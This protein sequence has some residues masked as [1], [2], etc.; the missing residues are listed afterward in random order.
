MK[1]N[2]VIAFR[3]PADF[4]GR[5]IDGSAASWNAQAFDPGD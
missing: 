4:L 3:N 2:I 5:P 1:E